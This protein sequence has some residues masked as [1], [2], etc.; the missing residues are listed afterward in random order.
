MTS[1]QDPFAAPDDSGTP[2]AQGY[3][4]PP[5]Y[6]TPPEAPGFGQPPA[7]G[8]T[9]YGTAPADAW[10]G[11]PLA[12]WGTRFKGYLVDFLISL[13]VQLVVGLIDPNIGQLAGFAVFLYFGWMTGTTGQTPGRKVA[14]VKILREADGQPLGGPMGI[15]RGFAHFLDALP[16]LLGF[17]WPIWDKKKQTFADKLVKSVAIKV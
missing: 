10:Q 1:P 8:A 11:P 17:F 14:G 16:L 15:V 6:G 2:P 3:G 9:P 5:A 13:A 4:Q 7:Y 12:S